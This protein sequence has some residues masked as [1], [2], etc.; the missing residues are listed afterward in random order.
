MK[1]SFSPQPK[2]VFRPR[3]I[4]LTF[5]TPEDWD[6]FYSL[7]SVNDDELLDVAAMS[8][9]PTA[10]FNGRDMANVTCTILQGMDE[11]ANNY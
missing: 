3:S 5:E 7:M 1:C 4:I 8:A 2:E 10:R 6:A 11:C 9:G